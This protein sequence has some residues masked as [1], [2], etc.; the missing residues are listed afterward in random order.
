MSILFIF[1]PLY[2]PKIGDIF[3]TVSLIKCNDINDTIKTTYVLSL[4]LIVVIGIIEF[5]YN[6]IDS[7]KM[8]TIL[9]IISLVIQTLVILFFAMSKQPYATSIMFMILII[10]MSLIIKDSFNKKVA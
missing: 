1:L 5:I 3:Y 10:K 4:A 7:K 9:N 2:G 8:R 6:F